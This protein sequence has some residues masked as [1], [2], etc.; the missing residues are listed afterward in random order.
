M[1][2]SSTDPAMLSVES[3]KR[4]AAQCA[5][6][7]H[8]RSHF[9]Y[10]GIG[11]GSTIV[12]VVE[13][14]KALSRK[15]NSYDSYNLSAMSFVPT[16]YASRQL[17]LSHSL[18]V[19][20]FDALPPHTLLDISFDGADEVDS[21]LNCIKGGGA[22]LYQEK[23]VAT[24]SRQFICVADYRKA[25]DRLLRL[26]HAIPI[27]VEPLAVQSVNETLTAEF[28]TA[29]A[30]VRQGGLQ[31]EGPLKTDQGNF[32]L[33]V[34][35]GQR[36]R[37]IE[38]Q[39]DGTEVEEVA[40]QAVLL[41][42][43]DVEAGWKEDHEMGV[44]EV[45]ALAKAIKGIEGVLSVGIFSGEDG[46]EAQERDPRVGGQK[47]VVVYFGMRDGSVEVR[48]R[49]KKVEGV[50]EARRKMV[51]REEEEVKRE[52]EDVK[53]EDEEVKKEEKEVKKEVVVM[54]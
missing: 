26:W 49:R 54:D 36:A 35:L 19:L 40:E 10:I 11:S 5:V 15:T 2:S 27:E 17:L 30:R 14:I 34:T 39:R 52:E 18:P 21:D 13:A 51:K 32:I 47:P 46:E 48:R 50:I 4:L 43:E 38:V 1:P 24:H 44:W 12:Y 16:G 7:E 45:E 25:Q 8:F 28:G 9:R 29:M 3:A 22:C 53:R 6:N 41:L 37:R 31:K 20:S 23:L 42:K 33:D